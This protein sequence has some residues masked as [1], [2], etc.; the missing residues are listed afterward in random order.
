MI[1]Y[2]A[3]FADDQRCNPRIM[4][5]DRHLEL[6]ITSRRLDTLDKVPQR[7]RRNSLL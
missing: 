2:L 6:D 7:I 4:K 5:G 3:D 1:W